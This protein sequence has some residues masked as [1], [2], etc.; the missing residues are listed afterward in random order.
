MVS[1]IGLAI[2]ATCIS[3]IGTLV[4][5]VK[6]KEKELPEKFMLW[7]V[8]GLFVYLPF[9][10][11]SV[12]VATCIFGTYIGIVRW[13]YLYMWFIIFFAISVILIGCGFYLMW[14]REKESEVNVEK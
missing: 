3:V 1:V 5:Y 10:G 2:I 4:G 7:G 14:K 11:S 13:F 12:T 9:L 8:I 6:A